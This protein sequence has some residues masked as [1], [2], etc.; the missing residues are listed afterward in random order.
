MEKT[1]KKL[2]Q[3]LKTAM[4]AELAGHYFYKNAAEATSD[5]QGKETFRRMAQEEMGHFKYLQHQYKN[6]AEKG[7]YDLERALATNS[8]RHAAHP[9]FTREIRKRIKDSHFEISALT[10]GLKLELDAM[11]FYRA[12][13]EEAEEPEVKAFYQE[14]AEWEEDHYRAFEKELE[15]LKEEYFEANNFV[16]M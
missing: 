6:L 4:Q 1:E 5:P 13:A 11:R 15:S 14:L 2:L 10:I 9:I 16:P 3:G 12:R 7:A 8:Y